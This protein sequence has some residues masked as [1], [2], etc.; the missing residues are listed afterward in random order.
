MVEPAVFSI[1]LFQ[2]RPHHLLIEALLMPLC[3][4]IH[5]YSIYLNICMSIYYELSVLI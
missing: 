5:I 1:C 4:V 2:K 3:I